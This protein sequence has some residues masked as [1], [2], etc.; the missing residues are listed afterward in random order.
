MNFNAGDSKSTT[1][2]VHELTETE[3]QAVA[4]GGTGLGGLALQRAV[5]IYVEQKRIEALYQD[6]K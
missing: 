2:D 1:N 4:G 3:L 5:E 6:R